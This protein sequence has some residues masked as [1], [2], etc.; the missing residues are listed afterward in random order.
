MSDKGAGYLEAAKRKNLSREELKERIEELRE[1]VDLDS[2]ELREILDEEN[3]K[4]EA[5][6]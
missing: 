5:E 2:D 1:Y 4:T 3:D 6:A